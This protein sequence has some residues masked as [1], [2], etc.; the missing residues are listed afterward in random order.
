MKKFLEAASK[1]E[2]LKAD[3]QALAA[4]FDSKSADKE[5]L[6]ADAI[7]LAAKHGFTLTDDDFKTSR[8][9]ELTEDEMMAVADGGGASNN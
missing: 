3:V 9:T 1:N 5:A 4:K 6:K 7:E 8:M 2:V